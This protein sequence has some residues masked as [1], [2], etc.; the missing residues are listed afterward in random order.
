MPHAQLTGNAAAATGAGTAKLLVL[1]LAIFWG[2]NWI[3]AA[4]ALREVS[5][6]TLRFAG[7]SIG[8]A[9]LF[10]AAWLTGKSHKV[11]PGE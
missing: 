3:A 7:S 10:A 5:P 9:T 11:P 8:T 6:W 1:L 2:L 4:F